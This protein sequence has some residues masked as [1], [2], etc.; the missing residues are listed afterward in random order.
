MATSLLYWCWY[1][2]FD[3]VVMFLVFKGETTVLSHIYLDMSSILDVKYH[4]P[5]ILTSV[6]GFYIM[7]PPPLLFLFGSF[8]YSTSVPIEIQILFQG[9]KSITML[10]FCSHKSLLKKIIMYERF[11]IFLLMCH[12]K[13][14]GS[15][16]VNSCIHREFWQKSLTLIINLILALS[17]QWGYNKYWGIVCVSCAVSLNGDALLLHGSLKGVS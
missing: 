15:R 9:H 2:L 14:N 12:F 6:S 4:L 16:G 13:R 10:Y 17:F 3:L 11:N 1:F 5:L 8:Q 7:H